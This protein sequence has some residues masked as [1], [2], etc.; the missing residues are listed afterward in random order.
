MRFGKISKEAIWQ[1]ATAIT[2]LFL[3]IFAVGCANCRSNNG[4][5]PEF[6][7]D[8]AL[9]TLMVDGKLYC[10]N[11]DKIVDAPDES[12]IAGR[13]T[14]Y[15]QPSRVPETNDTSNT[16]CCVNQPYAFTDNGLLVYAIQ[17]RI[18]NSP[19]RGRVDTWLYCEPYN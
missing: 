13:I 7:E 16:I 6:S 8:Y 1:I 15:I 12:E 5:Q 9:P 11:L 10:C 19:D 4:R 2:I 18:A 17:V 14:N 3:L